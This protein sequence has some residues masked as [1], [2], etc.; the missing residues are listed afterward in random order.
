MSQNPVGFGADVHGK[1]G[2]GRQRY[3]SQVEPDDLLKYGLIPEFIGRLPVT[4]TLE[5]LDEVALLNILTEPRNAIVKQ[6]QKLLGLEGVELQFEEGALKAVVEKATERGTGARALRSIIENIML[7]VMYHLPSRKGTDL[8]LRGT[9]VR[10]SS[11]SH[12]FDFKTFHYP[13]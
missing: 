4:A 12:L 10:I 8:P 9:Q 3:L 11:P 13:Q 1:K 6:Y 7:D 5:P 2:K